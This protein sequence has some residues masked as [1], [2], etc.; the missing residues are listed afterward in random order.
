MRKLVY[1]VA[2]TLDSYI[3]GPNGEYDFLLFE[4][5]GRDAILAEYPETMP[6]PPARPSA[7]P[8]PRIGISTRSSWAAAPTNPA[9][10]RA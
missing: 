9:C 7:S 10:G 4:G 3:A 1:Y 6:T 5:E 2:A 8:T